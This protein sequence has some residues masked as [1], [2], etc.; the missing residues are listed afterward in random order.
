MAP[1]VATYGPLFTF[2]VLV[3]LPFHPTQKLKLTLGKMS[4]Y[5]RVGTFRV[6][7]I[8]MFSRALSI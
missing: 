6:S 1:L 4:S 3:F 8:A 5:L 7:F 2:F